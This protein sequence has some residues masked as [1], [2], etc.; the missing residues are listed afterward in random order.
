M[1]DSRL[2]KSN[3]CN[4]ILLLFYT[5]RHCKKQ[6]VTLMFGENGMVWKLFGCSN[7]SALPLGGSPP[8]IDL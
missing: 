8:Q 6:F 5:I 4:R 1:R 7:S 2:S 3:L